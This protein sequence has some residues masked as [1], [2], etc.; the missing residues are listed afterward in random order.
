MDAG[1]H[2]I[3]KYYK[4]LYNSKEVKY[5]TRFYKNENKFEDIKDYFDRLEDI[6]RRAINSGKKDLLYNCFFRRYV[7]KKENINNKYTDE[8]KEKIIE[9]QKESL[10]PWLD[11]LNTYSKEAYWIK[12]YIFQGMV[13]VGTY[14]EARDVF[15][16]R[17]NK[18]ISPFI[19]FNLTAVDKLMNYIKQYVY[20]TLRDKTLEDIIGNNSFNTLYYVL[21]QE[22]RN[23][24]S[25]IT[26]GIWIKYN[27]GSKEDAYKLWN[28]IV[29]QNTFWC[30]KERSRC[31]D[32]LCGPRSGD[33]YV[34]YTN[35]KNDNPVI[36]R[37]AIRFIGNKI[38][39]IRG[40]LDSSQN[41]EPSLTEV[42]KKKLD[43]FDF[44]GDEAKMT[45][46]KKIEHN[47]KITELN[48]KT[49]KGIS[50]TREEVD[51][52]FEINEK[53]YTFAEGEDKRIH[54]I[55]SKNIIIDPDYLLKAS[56]RVVNILKYASVDLKNNKELVTKIMKSKYFLVDQVGEKLKDDIKFMWPIIFADPMYIR[57]AGPNIKKHIGVAL[58]VLRHNLEAFRYLNVN[59]LKSEKFVRL[60]KEI[61]GF[62]K[63]YL[64]SNNCDI[65]PKGDLNEDK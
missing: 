20:K 52:I 13:G 56:K 35:D 58:Y 51:F 39:E 21:L 4:N 3:E 14:S 37:I 59:L 49:N 26:N 62:E 54:E 17:S 24:T 40:V 28:S 23:N 31:M 25:N 12:Y 9:A 60:A 64:L 36:P 5:A 16:K 1:I 7:I 43:T 55:R 61:P 30:T 15:M 42:V 48:R 8:E 65:I 2:F 57:N 22:C 19:E 29:Y 41:L 18:T 63:K 44:L 45:S 27:Q 34:Y 53:I 33:F 47:R 38:H 6:S 46:L 11:Y 32:Q 10:I 50:L